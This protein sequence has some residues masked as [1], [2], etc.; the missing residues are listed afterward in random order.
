[1]LKGLILGILLGILLVAGGIYYYFSSGHAPVATSA[2]PIPFEKRL[3]RVALHAYL[4]KLA[5]PAPQVAA[6]E[7][8]VLAGAKVYKEHCAMCHGLPNEPKTA[9]AQGMFPAAPETFPAPPRSW[10]RSAGRGTS[11][12]APCKPL[13]RQAHS[14]RPPLPEVPGAPAYPGKHAVPRARASFQTVSAAP[15]WPPARAPMRNSN[16]CLR[17]PT[18]FRAKSLESSP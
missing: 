18:G 1:M 14:L 9:E 13:P 15:K 3:V 7:A 17:Q 8:N 11:R 16:K 12:S 6:D 10:A 2:P 5:H 4:D